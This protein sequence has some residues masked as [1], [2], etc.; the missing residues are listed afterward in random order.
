MSSTRCEARLYYYVFDSERCV[1]C[2]KRALETAPLECS[3]VRGFAWLYYAGGRSLKGGVQEAF[4]AIREGFKEDQ[5]HEAAFTQLLFVGL[6]VQYWA[7]ADLHNQLLAANQLLQLGLQRGLTEATGWAHYFR[8]CVFYHLNDLARAE[9]EFGVVFG[10]R[11]VAHGQPFSQSAFGLA[12]VHQARGASDRAREVVDSLV[13]YT[14][15]MRHERVRADAEAFGA[16]LALQRGSTAEALRWAVSY[17]SNMPPVPMNTFHVALVSRAKILVSAETPASQADAAQALACLRDQATTSHN[18]R[19]L[20]EVLAL[21]ALLDDARG[22]R[23]RAL[24]TLRQAVDLAEPGGLIRVFV[25]LG[26]KM[27]ILLRHLYVQNGGAGR[28]S[29]EEY[30]SRL[31]VAFGEAQAPRRLP[32]EPLSGQPAPDAGDLIE[33]LS[34]R[35]LDVLVLLSER[36]TDK[37]IA[38][39]LFI[40]TNTVKRHASN[41][42]QKMLVAGRRDAV[43]KAVAL[44]LIPAVSSTR[45]QFG[46]SR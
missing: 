1:A 43:A 29:V 12:S 19:Y 33:P 39:E 41:I 45:A 35:E 36:L 34:E 31:L 23:D 44:G 15:E 38:H 6:G 22:R 20:I 27:G 28:R 18:T 2:A 3:T 9:S 24:T 25:D 37:E 13:A 40:S 17:H 42:Y 30:L 5:L 16:W 11:Y 4:E 14:L 26:P 7:A 21:Q 10:Q 46:S 32:G 8:G